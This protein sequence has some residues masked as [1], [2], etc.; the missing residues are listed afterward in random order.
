MC[1][2]S[3]KEALEAEAQDTLY[4]LMEDYMERSGLSQSEVYQIIREGLYEAN[5]AYF[6]KHSWHSLF[7]CSIL[8]IMKDRHK[9]YAALNARFVLENLNVALGQDFHT[10]TVNQVNTLLKEADADRYQNQ[11]MLMALELGI[12]MI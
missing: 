5:Y 9:P 2:V 7:T 8:Y 10:L 12:I 3:V 11:R 6:I 4:N 1:Y